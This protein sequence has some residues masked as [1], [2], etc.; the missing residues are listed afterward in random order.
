MN[1]YSNIYWKKNKKYYDSLS[2][3]ELCNCQWCTLFYSKAR[4]EYPEIA[5][6]LAQLGI[7]IGKPFEVMS[8]DPDESGAVEYIAV[9]YI[10]FGT[11]DT[12]YNRSI[13]D[14]NVRITQ[15]YPNPEVEG[16]YFVLEIGPMQLE[17]C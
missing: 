1:S 3:D 16:D 17:K 2:Y 11:C 8:I 14:V 13:G 12:D 6:W 10:A 4:Q 9:Q 15:S 7:D 5:D